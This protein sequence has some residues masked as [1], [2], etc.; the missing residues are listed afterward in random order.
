M[1]SASSAAALLPPLSFCLLWRLLYLTS[2]PTGWTAC[3]RSFLLA[4]AAWGTACVIISETLSFL[5]SLTFWPVLSAWLV[6]TVA[7]A[8]SSPRPERSP[9]AVARALSPLRTLS[10]SSALLFLYLVIVVVVIAAT[11]WLAP[12]NNTDAMQY[13]LPRVLHWIQNQTVAFYPTNTSRQ[14]GL[15]PW[16]EYAMLQFQLLSGDDH[17]ANLVQWFA[18]LGSV[19]GITIL[20][21]TWGESRRGPVF[22]A[23]VLASTPLGILQASSTKNDYVLAFWLIC[24]VYFATCEDLSL[25]PT[26]LAVGAALGLAILTKQTAFIFLLPWCAWLGVGL[27]R[28]R[29]PNRLRAAMAVVALAV[30]INLPHFGRNV[31]LF[32]SPLGG[33][34]TTEGIALT[35]A[36]ATPRLVVST[37]IKNLSLQLQTPSPTLTERLKTAVSR[38]HDL[39]GAD[40]N[41]PRTTVLS[42]RF[43]TLGTNYNDMVAGSPLHLGLLLLVVTA[44]LVSARV[45]QN[46]PF[47]TCLL[48]LVAS[49][50]IFAAVLRFQVS[51][52]RLQLPLVLLFAAPAGY[53]LA[54]LRPSVLGNLLIAVLAV[55]SMPWLLFNQTRPLVGPSS[56]WRLDRQELYFAARPA[57]RRPYVE[58]IHFVRSRECASVGLDLR[59]TH[60]QYPFWAAMAYGNPGH[61]RIEHVNVRNTSAQ[62]PRGPFTPC[63]IIMVDHDP[64]E[65]LTSGSQRYALAWSSDATSFGSVRVYEAVIRR[66]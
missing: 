37:V 2:S 41:D 5:S 60:W 27:L 53:V 28:T 46:R 57:L 48:A 24:F 66:R 14:L 32:G 56:V 26:Q 33:A 43:H 38:L 55:S 36:A 6:L 50:L 19:L 3:N 7:T 18:M 42:E 13:H 40:L 51:N 63:A 11:A 59:G 35:A 17:Y 8:V 25:W 12:P 16:A 20:V 62:L 9:T 49:Y 30:A 58:A 10:L 21:R 44:P 61:F 52:V 4:A 65:S 31:L 45:R 22:A 29:Q 39:L 1:I 47:L 34:G 54:Q 64:L 15:N 23:V